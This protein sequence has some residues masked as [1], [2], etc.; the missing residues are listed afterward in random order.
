MT[1]SV[2][3]A[4]LLLLL[5]LLLRLLLLLLLVV[6]PLVLLLPSRADAMLLQANGRIFSGGVE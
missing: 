6:P 5:L 1:N 4:A 3:L 2:A